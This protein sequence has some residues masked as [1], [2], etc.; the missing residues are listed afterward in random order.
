MSTTSNSSSLFTSSST[1]KSRSN[2]FSASTSGSSSS[3]LTKGGLKR[4]RDT[5]SSEL[6]RDSSLPNTKRHLRTTI[7]NNLNAAAVERKLAILQTN[8]AELEKKVREKDQRLDLL[9]KDR[10]WLNDRETEEREAREREGKEAREREVKLKHE[11]AAAKISLSNLEVSHAEL[12]DAHSKLERSR[13]HEVS[14][15]KTQLEETQKQAM[16]LEARVEEEKNAAKIAASNI[17]SASSSTPSLSQSTSSIPD[18]DNRLLTAELKRQATYLRQLESTN[19]RLNADVV[20]LKSDNAI[21]RDRNATVEVLKEEKRG[22]ESRLKMKEVEVEKLVREVVR[23][24][25]RSSSSKRSSL[26]LN[27]STLATHLGLDQDD[28][29][30]S[31]G[32]NDSLKDLPHPTVKEISE[33]AALRLEH[34]ALL[35]QHGTTLSE[36]AALRGEKE[37]LL[38]QTSSR[39]NLAVPEVHSQ[40]IITSNLQIQLRLK[41]EEL[42]TALKELAFL[43]AAVARLTSDNSSLHNDA[44]TVAEVKHYQALFNDAKRLNAD[45]RSEIETSLNKLRQHSEQDIETEKKNEERDQLLQDQLEKMRTEL[46]SEKVKREELEKSLD[47]V[48]QELFD[49]RGEVAGGRHIP[50]NTRVLEMK[51]NPH[52]EWEMSHTAVLERLKG[53]NQALLKRLIDIEAVL[54]EAGAAQASQASETKSDVSVSTL[55]P[56]ESLDIAVK[57]KEDLEDVLKQKEKRLLRLQQVFKAKSAEFR[58][59][60]ESIMGVK[61]AFYPNGQVR[62]TSLFDL[63]ASFVFGPDKTVKV[64]SQ[65]EPNGMNMQLVATGEGGPQDLPDLMR[66]WIETEACIPG[67]LASITLECYESSKRLRAT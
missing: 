20:V 65:T 6:E 35:D 30:A 29:D 36:L 42:E 3:I 24:D 62:V 16:F 44:N 63:N 13:N 25:H 33:L 45:L 58:E 57:D 19:T 53:E 12:Q 32:V 61:L 4:D 48:E 56:R 26:P 67:F 8:C 46:Q 10:R 49:L 2:N 22:L 59:A 54:K 1:S 27:P 51:D 7:N 11:L 17:A 18:T 40:N 60:I 38:Q 39:G 37:A 50:P 9:E 23:R 52:A 21:L 28:V 5:F 66:Y 47:I 15:L 64:S 31:V 34:A 14:L 41:D 43:E 55:V